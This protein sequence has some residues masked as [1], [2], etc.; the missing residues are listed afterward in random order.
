M[1]KILFRVMVMFFCQC[2]LFSIEYNQA[3]A[4]GQSKEVKAAKAAYFAKFLK[5]IN[6]AEYKPGPGV[7]SNY[8]DLRM[9]VSDAVL[10][11]HD[12]DPEEE[13]DL[14]ETVNLTGFSFEVK[15]Y[16]VCTNSTPVVNGRNPLCPA[17][18]TLSSDG[19]TITFFPV[20]IQ[21]DHKKGKG[22]FFK[23]FIY[24]KIVLKR[25]N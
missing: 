9:T 1:G 19:K 24:D 4:A 2:I 18:A 23:N 10:T 22:V 6:G 11:V 12:Y 21:W 20:R 14:T 7:N 13:K 3:F 16:A 25:T 15:D 8:S 17:M 5:K